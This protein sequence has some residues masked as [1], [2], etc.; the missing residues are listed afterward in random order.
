MRALR[1]SDLLAGRRRSPQPDA[2]VHAW[3]DAALATR[4]PLGLFGEVADPVDHSPLGNYPQV[5]SHAAF[6]LAV[7]DPKQ[8][9]LGHP[10]D[11][12]DR[13]HAGIVHADRHSARHHGDALDVAAQRAELR[14]DREQTVQ[15]QR[16]VDLRRRG[17][18]PANPGR[19]SIPM[20]TSGTCAAITGPVV[21]GRSERLMCATAVGVNGPA[22][23]RAETT[24]RPS[25][26]RTC[27]SR[28]SLGWGLLATAS[29]VRSCSLS[30]T[31]P[32]GP[33]MSCAAISLA[34][35]HRDRRLV[36]AVRRARR[37]CAEHRGGQGTVGE[38]DRAAH[39]R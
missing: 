27:R 12:G 35:R 3:L 11:D 17:P 13:R 28:N 8:L 6:V 18:D 5:Q 2:T 29:T 20:S 32:C 34:E 31:T 24:T 19:P 10:H 26:T 16:R 33:W 39:E 7:A 25:R 21:P 1:L 14:G 37:R 30:T 4:G 15:R 36:G 22:D 38:E 9:R 23:I